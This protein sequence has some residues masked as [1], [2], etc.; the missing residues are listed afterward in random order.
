MFGV[1]PRVC[2]G[3]QFT[4]TQATLV[5]AAMIKAPIERADS[6]PVTP[7]GIVTTQPGHS[8]LFRLQRR[9]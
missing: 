2:I 5:L 8:P 1:G 3:A 7:V 6:E 4:L 9:H